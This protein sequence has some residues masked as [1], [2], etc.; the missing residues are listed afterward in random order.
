[1]M[2]WDTIN[3]RLTRGL[4]VSA[5][6]IALLIAA[7]AHAFDFDINWTFD[8]SGET[9][10]GGD[11]GL[12]N[13]RTYQSGGPDN[14]SL[15]ATAWSDTGA[16][17]SGVGNDFEAASLRRWSGGFGVQNRLS[18]DTSSPEHAVDNNNNFDFVV[19][20]LD[21]AVN[22]SSVTMNEYGTGDSDITVWV[23]NT[24]SDFS[25]ELDLAGMDFSDLDSLYTRDENY[26]NDGSPR[27]ALFAEDGNLMGNVIIVA[28]TILPT[29]NGV[30]D[31]FKIKK[32]G[33]GYDE[34][35][36]STEIPEPSSLGVIAFGLA[37]ICFIRRRRRTL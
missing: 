8:G 25:T 34:P 24:D 12:G 16:T 29:Y 32:L 5:T 9:L 7:P 6:C 31:Y 21:R 2:S 10:V 15:R 35:I 36:V 23:G 4:A 13:S 14:V 30:K 20:E 26:V 37:A 11:T 28:A 22:L 17:N 19:F 1:M 18:N 27:T 33:G 3:Q